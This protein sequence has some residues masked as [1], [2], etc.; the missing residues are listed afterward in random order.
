MHDNRLKCLH[1]FIDSESI[2]RV[3]T[4]FFQREDEF[5]FRL[6][7]LLPSNHHVVQKL[8][9]SK[10]PEFCQCSIAFMMTVLRENYF[11][12]EESQDY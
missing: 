3:K 9:F 4:K 1:T 7:V 5:N 10:H 11:N 8:I 12:S 6:P 2:I